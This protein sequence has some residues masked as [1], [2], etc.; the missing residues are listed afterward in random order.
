MSAD[1]FCSGVRRAFKATLW[2]VTH[3]QL[4]PPQTARSVR[5]LSRQLP[6][7]V[8]G[9]YFWDGFRG[10]V[11][12][13]SSIYL[14]FAGADVFFRPLASKASPVRIFSSQA[15]PL[16]TLGTSPLTL[17]TFFFPVYCPSRPNR[18]HFT[19]RRVCTSAAKS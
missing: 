2:R 16:Q 9:S 7:H 19:A 4:F 8:K 15:R 13:L 3:W 6:F 14:L 5:V 17:R 12:F 11:A 18:E 1:R 10:G